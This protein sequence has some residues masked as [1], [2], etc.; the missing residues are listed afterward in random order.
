MAR[1]LEPMKQGLV[2]EPTLVRD[3]I[4]AQPRSLRDPCRSDEPA[5]GVPNGGASLSPTAA[6][7][8]RRKAQ[9]GDDPR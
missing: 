2:N 7:A 3:D 5:G 8:A 9:T 6:V 1:S 4:E